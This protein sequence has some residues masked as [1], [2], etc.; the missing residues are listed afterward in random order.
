[1]LISS[2]QNAELLAGALSSKAAQTF[3]ISLPLAAVFL[4]YKSSPIDQR[5][6]S[7]IKMKGF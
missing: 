6:F 3:M 2:S 5:Y 7:L 1:V 4:P